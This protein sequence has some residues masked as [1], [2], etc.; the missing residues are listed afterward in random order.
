MRAREFRLSMK[1]FVSL[2]GLKEGVVVAS[3]TVPMTGYVHVHCWDPDSGA[4]AEGEFPFA[5]T[6][7]AKTRPRRRG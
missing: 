4:L 7:K 2:L 5:E 6:I 3:V 1:D